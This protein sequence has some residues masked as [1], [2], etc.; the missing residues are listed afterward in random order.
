MDT[1]VF[2]TDAEIKKPARRL[3]H[4]T[5]SGT[6]GRSGRGKGKGKGLEREWLQALA[7]W[8]RVVTFDRLGRGGK[9]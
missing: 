9:F 3:K 4:R 7:W 8:V 6:G 5:G 1:T 2:V